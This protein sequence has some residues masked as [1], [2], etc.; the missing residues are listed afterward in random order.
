M[1]SQI[2]YQMTEKDVND[3][4]KKA[5]KGG[6]RE[7]LYAPLNVRE[8]P[9]KVV[10]GLLGRNE[11]TVNLYGKNGVIPSRQPSGE[12]GIRYFKLGDVIQFMLE[13]KV[14]KEK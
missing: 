13:G 7:L 10:A 1:E 4:I 8:L 11:D 6:V 2:V 9:A 3:T 12:G 5:L 14:R